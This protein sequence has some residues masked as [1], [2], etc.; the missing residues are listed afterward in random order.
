MMDMHIDGLDSL[1]LSFK[2]LLEIPYDFRHDTLAGGAKIVCAKIMAYLH[3]HHKRTGQLANAWEVRDVSSGDDP[4]FLVTTIAD[5]KVTR[6]GKIR[7]K[8]RIH[9]GSGR[10]RAGSSHHG[11]GNTMADIAYYLNYGTT[12][13]DATHWF[14]HAME[15]VEEEFAGYMEV[16]LG[17]FFDERGL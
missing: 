4:C 3:A 17:K 9:Q 16:S 13:V 2:D 5:E 6:S 15:E 1:A 10:H 14:E 8:Q 7:R 11:S 12:R